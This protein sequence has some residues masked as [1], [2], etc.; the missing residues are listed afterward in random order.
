MTN[1]ITTS[2]LVSGP[3]ST[4][5]QSGQSVQEWVAAHCDAL[6]GKTPSGDK[7]VTTWTS[8]AGP[9]EVVTE[10]EPGESDEEFMRRHKH[11]FLLAMIEA[12]PVP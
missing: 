9:E 8:A 5:H 1:D 6:E 12:Q 4:S 7:L 2:G 10:R 11:E 3:L